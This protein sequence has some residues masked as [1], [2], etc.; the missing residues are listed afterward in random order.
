VDLDHQHQSV[1]QIFPALVQRVSAAQRAGN[2]FDPAYEASCSF[3]LDDGMKALS[4]SLHMM[5]LAPLASQ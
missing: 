1:T 5:D 2:L 3:R 4:H